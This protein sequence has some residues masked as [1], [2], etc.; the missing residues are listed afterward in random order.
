[1]FDIDYF[2]RYNDTFGHDA[3]DA[4]LRMVG[5]T[6]RET[7]SERTQIMIRHGGEEFA[8]ILFDTNEEELR[9]WAEKLRGAVYEKHLEAPTKDVADY[10][11]VSIGIAMKKL[12][13]ENQRYEELLTE[14][15]AALY[16]A[17]RAGRNQVAYLAG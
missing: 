2:K 5:Q 13:E 4:C 9:R 6:I 11:T 15:D 10:V 17:K 3:G 1:M 12:G 14:A 16:E 8:V 7:F